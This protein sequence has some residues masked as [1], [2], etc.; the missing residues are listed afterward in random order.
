MSRSIVFDH[1]PK[2]HHPSRLSFTWRLFSHVSLMA[3]QV[4]IRLSKCLTLQFLIH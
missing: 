2:H 3:A 1:D 4:C